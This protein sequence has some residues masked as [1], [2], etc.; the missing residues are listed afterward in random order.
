MARTLLTP[1]AKAEEALAVCDRK[2]AKARVR[3][4]KH[5]AELAGAK[6]EVI[7]LLRERTY[8]ASSPYLPKGPEDEL[9][10]EPGA[11]PE[12]DLDEFAAA[13]G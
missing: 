6:A 12:D 2:L 4:S 7:E 1:Q 3:E 10:D 13:D 9:V 5:E 11:T 8:L